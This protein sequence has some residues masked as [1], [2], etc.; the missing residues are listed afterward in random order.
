MPARYYPRK[1]LVEGETDRGVIAGLA[2]ANGV[3][4][5]HPPNSPVFIGTRGGVDEIL[6]PG[7]LEAELGASGLEALGV[8]VDANSDAA[9]RWNDLGAWCGNEF[10]DLPDQIPAVGLEV[11]HSGGP[12]FGIWIMPDNRFRGMLEDWLV[13]LIPE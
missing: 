1:L 6:K 2:E 3:P 10:S 7:V 9:I 11:V 4:W 5:P 8:V 13:G 12:R